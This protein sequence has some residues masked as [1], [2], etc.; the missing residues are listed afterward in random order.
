MKWMS[1]FVAVAVLVGVGF[2][3]DARQAVFGGGG[4]FIPDVNDVVY[5][6]SMAHSFGNCA[7][8]ELGTYAG[9]GVVPSGQWGLFNLGIGE[10]LAIGG[11]LRRTDGEIFSRTDDFG[12]AAPNPGLNLW[13]A[14]NIGAARV[15]LGFYMASYS[16]KTTDDD[17]DTESKY[18]SHI[19]SFKL[20]SDFD[21]G[22]GGNFAVALGV[23]LNGFSS[24]N[25]NAS[26]Q[27]YTDEMTGGAEISA[28]LRGFLPVGEYTKV[29]PVVRFSTFSHSCEITD[30]S[31]N[32]TRYGDYS[33]MNLFVGS[34][35]NVSVMED[36][37]V[38]L[39]LGM[40][41]TDT[42]DEIDTA[43]RTEEKTFILPALSLNTEIPLKPWLI[44]RAGLT[45][46]FGSATHTEGGIETTTSFSETDN[47]FASIGAGIKFGDFKVDFT[48]SDDD[49]FEGPWFIG[50]HACNAFKVSLGYNWE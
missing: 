46:N 32:V 45:K 37:L 42:K 6:P 3:S 23:D 24:E 7:Q 31:G 35:V 2:A 30:Y 40:L 29:V 25:T 44:A 15:G 28:M 8:L 14:Y 16:S 43:N 33:E 19:Y 47:M 12:Y 26:G 17:S 5:I 13:G 22:D 34:G 50:G 4:I 1:L 11:A 10:N 27:T 41:M 20:S 21:I 38:S 49:L 39:G 9:D 36:G 18:S 48:I